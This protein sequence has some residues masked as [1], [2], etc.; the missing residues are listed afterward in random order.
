M[1]ELLPL[2]RAALLEQGLLAQAK[3]AIVVELPT[4]GGKTLLT[5][6]RIL[7]ALNQFDADKG[8]VAYVAPTRA[9]SAQLTR[10]LRRDFEPVGIRVEQLTGAVEVDAFEERL[11]NEFDQPFHVLVVTPEKLSLVIRNKKV[12]RP[13]ALVV[14]DEAHNLENNQRGLRIEF[15][16]ATVKRDCPQANSCYSC[17]IWKAPNQWPRERRGGW[18]E[19]W[20]ER[21]EGLAVTVTR[22]ELRAWRR[23]SPEGAAAER[24]T[25]CLLAG[26]G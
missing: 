9:L 21:G 18:A 12:A 14:M 2:Q 19:L 5:E 11:L 10:R 1:F 16:L 4:S 26:Y 13:L 25:G 17:L 20:E 15:L 23:A 7:Q 6:F 3:T 8:W 24:A 22:R